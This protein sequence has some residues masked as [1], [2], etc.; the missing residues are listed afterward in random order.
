MKPPYR[1]QEGDGVGKSR[2]GGGSGASSEAST[3]AEGLGH[4][5]E[6]KSDLAGAVKQQVWNLRTP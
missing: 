6:V 5:L 1:H 4:G 2:P 3:V